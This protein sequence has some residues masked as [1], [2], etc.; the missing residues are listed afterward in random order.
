MSF[1]NIYFVMTKLPELQLQIINLWGAF[2]WEEPERGLECVAKMVHELQG[3]MWSSWWHD[4]SKSTQNLIWKGRSR[5]WLL[6]FLSFLVKGMGT[7]HPCRWGPVFIRNCPDSSS[8]CELVRWQIN[9]LCNISNRI[10]K[11]SLYFSWL[12]MQLRS[13]VENLE[14]TIKFQKGKLPIVHLYRGN[15]CR[16][17]DRVPASCFRAW[18]V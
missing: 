7:F 17:R 13:N 1:K 11:H 5:G 3:H 6:H 10:K 4:T 15:H 14:Y 18:G 12:Q 8:P 9:C 16:P 2:S